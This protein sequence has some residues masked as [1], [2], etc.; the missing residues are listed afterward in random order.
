MN[1]II[2]RLEGRFA[3]CEVSTDGG[4]QFFVRIPRSLIPSDSSEGDAI[5]RKNGVWEFDNEY[6]RQQHSEL[7]SL[8]GRLFI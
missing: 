7:R 4:E 2:D 6:K 3:V 8:T 5:R 1:I